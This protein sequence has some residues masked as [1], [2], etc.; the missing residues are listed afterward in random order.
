MVAIVK[1]LLPPKDL[2]T[3]LDSEASSRSKV[4]HQ[5]HFLFLCDAGIYNM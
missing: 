4:L 2:Q 3:K 5:V 1:V